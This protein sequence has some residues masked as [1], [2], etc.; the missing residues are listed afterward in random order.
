MLSDIEIA[1]QVK[2]KNI[3][4]LAHEAG[5]ED[6][7]FEPYGRDKAKVKLNEN[8]KPHG[9][10]ILM[11]ATS[12]MPAGSGKTTTSIAL[13]QGL[14]RLGEKAVVALREPSLGPCFGMKGGAAGGGYSQ[15]LPMESIN[16]HFTGDFHAISAANNL[17]AAMLDSARHFGKIDL[18]TIIWKRVVDMNDR[19]LRN[20]VTGLGGAGNGVPTEA[21]FDITVASELM[22][23]LC[24]AT[25]L[26]DLRNRV[27]RLV[28]GIKRDGTAFTCEELG[29]TGSVMALLLEAIKP[30][31]VQTIEGNLAFVHGGPFAN[32]AHG[33]NSVIATRYA[34]T[35]GDWAV[36]EAG[37]GSDLGAE[38][39][40]DIKCRSAGLRPAVVVLVTSTKALKWHGLVPLPEIGK[41]NKEALIKGLA[42]LDA[43]IDNL[44]AFGPK[45]VVSLNHFA[46]DSEEEID[47]IRHRCEEKGVRFA[48]SDGFAKGGEGAIELA[49]A[50]MAAAAESKGELHF[51]YELEDSV[52]EKITKLATR[53]YGAK[54]IA[55]SDAAKKDLEQI[56]R[57]GF[58]K[59][60]IC[61]AKTP[62]SLSHEP[63]WLGRPTG[64]T[65]PVQRLILNAGAGFIVATTGAIMRMPGL[66][67][68]PNALHI[69][70]KDGRI[71]G[72]S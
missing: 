40:F 21:G 39:F 71:V 69:D 64:Y 44:L 33:C 58:E 30:N 15:V 2:L 11:T 28:L 27:N 16:L 9:T 42:N 31:L 22:A 43:H 41:P 13:V 45:V 35:L 66:P 67:K 20:I 37:F 26:E 8:K 25:D 47:I 51:A 55:L 36:T 12:G 57:L 48:V 56:V 10:L 46:S 72:L 52:T 50:V 6:S 49:K 29:A 38:K 62:Y 53:I 61:V 4:D 7:E 60:P 54:D 63:T 68:E 18:K 24:L 19:Q 3:E 59:L 5:L 23:V 14:K 32:I 65:L 1:Q 34:M 17:I 70:V